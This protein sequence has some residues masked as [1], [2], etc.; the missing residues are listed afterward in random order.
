MPRRECVGHLIERRSKSADFRRPIF[1]MGTLSIVPFAPF[2]GDAE[3][4]LD[5][6]PD[7]IAAPR[8]G[9]VHCRQETGQD[10]PDAA[11][12]G[13]VD[14]GKGFGFGLAGAEKEILRRQSGRE[15]SENP[16]R[17]IDADRFFPSRL[18]PIH[19]GFMGLPHVLADEE[20]R[21]R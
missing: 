1:Q 16:R 5:R 2:G 9:R 21:M 17:P 4:T 11:P 13:A 19:D 18:L 6:P 12:S 14:R 3:Q 15:I 10:Q 20:F 8:P 7:E